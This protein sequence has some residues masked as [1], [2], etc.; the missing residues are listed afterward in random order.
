MSC[1]TTSLCNQGLSLILKGFTIRLGMQF[2]GIK[3]KRTPSNA[4]LCWVWPKRWIWINFA[5][6]WLKF[7]ADKSIVMEKLSGGGIYYCG[8]MQMQNNIRLWAFREQFPTKFLVCLK[9]FGKSGNEK[10]S[11]GRNK[12]ERWRKFN[13]SGQKATHHL[14]LSFYDFAISSEWMFFHGLLSSL[15]RQISKKFSVVLFT[16][17]WDRR[18][19][20]LL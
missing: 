14:E 17:V 12:F 19:K 6:L 9:S 18:G 2:S 13:Y 16:R 7:F 20:G 8:K 5:K 11:N 4:K 15:L 3:L 1:S 10:L